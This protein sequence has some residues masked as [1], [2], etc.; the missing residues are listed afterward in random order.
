MAFLSSTFRAFLVAVLLAGMQGTLMV[1][2]LFLAQQSHIAKH[3]CI[4]R[5]KPDMQCNGKCFLA[6][7]VAEVHGSHDHATLRA[8]LLRADWIA[9]ST[10]ALLGHLVCPERA[11]RFP[12]AELGPSTTHVPLG[13]FRPP[14]GSVAGL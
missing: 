8:P 1:E 7:R 14:K 6:K 3:H 13:V 2:V 12:L 9:V 10:S 4:N 11:I 5:D